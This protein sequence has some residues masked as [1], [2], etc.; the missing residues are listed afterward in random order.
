MSQK[1]GSRFA[2]YFTFKLRDSMQKIARTKWN[3]VDFLF[4][5]FY[6]EFGSKKC[7]WK[8]RISA[9]SQTSY[10]QF[11][12]SRN[13]KKLFA[14][15]F[16]EIRKRTLSCKRLFPSMMKGREIIGKVAYLFVPPPPPLSLFPFPLPCTP[17][18]SPF[19]FPLP[20]TPPLPPLPPN[21]FIGN[22]VEAMAVF[23]SC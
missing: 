16:T 18:P 8:F 20:C 13:R 10:F 14:N 19:P 17:P 23:T 22:W 21:C 3:R 1:F 6:L 11:T 7:F 2:V 12:L 5:S 15:I 4:L 9:K